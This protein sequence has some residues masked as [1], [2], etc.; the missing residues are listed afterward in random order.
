MTNVILYYG[1]FNNVNELYK[2]SSKDIACIPEIIVPFLEATIF[3]P[4][5]VLCLCSN[6][7]DTVTD[8]GISYFILIL[9]YSRYFLI[10]CY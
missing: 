10:P 3:F 9:S 7:A 4:Y 8:H 1:F 6:E 5:T 2:K